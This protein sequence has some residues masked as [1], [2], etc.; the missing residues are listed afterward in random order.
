MRGVP[1]RR[2][3]LSIRLGAALFTGSLGV[4]G[5]EEKGEASRAEE[6]WGCVR[7]SVCTPVVMAGDNYFLYLI[8]R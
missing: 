5:G 2:S 7:P 4:L 6:G 8:Y 1:T 3:Y